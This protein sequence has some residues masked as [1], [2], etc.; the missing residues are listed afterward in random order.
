MGKYVLSTITMILLRSSITGKPTFKPI[1]WGGIPDGDSEFRNSV[2]YKWASV[3]TLSNDLYSRE[4]P[5]NFSIT[6]SFITSTVSFVGQI[7]LLPAI[8][9]SSWQFNESP[10]KVQSIKSSRD[11]LNRKPAGQLPETDP[12][13]N[14]TGSQNLQIFKSSWSVERTFYKCYRFEVLL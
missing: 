3:S 1:L 4:W 2:G 13:A 5:G 11:P 9:W 10:S 7:M 6:K 14:H 8:H 12:A